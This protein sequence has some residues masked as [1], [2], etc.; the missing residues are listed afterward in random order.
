MST[1]SISIKHSIEVLAVEI[2]QL[3]EIKR[4]QLG[5]RDVKYGY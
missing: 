3:N 4:I 2:R 1:L 5:M